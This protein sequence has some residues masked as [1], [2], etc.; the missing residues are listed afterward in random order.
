MWLRIAVVWL[1]VGGWGR[2]FRVSNTGGV[3]TSLLLAISFR[4]EEIE[5]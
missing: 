4:K 5:K 1:F 3:T 2:M